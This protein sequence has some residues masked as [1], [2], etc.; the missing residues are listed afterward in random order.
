MSKSLLSDAIRIH[1]PCVDSPA[2]AP[3]PNEGDLSTAA[4]EA[5]Q[6]DEEQTRRVFDPFHPRAKYSLHP[7][8]YLYFCQ[9]C[10]AIR[11]PR[12]VQEEIVSAFCPM[13]FF[14]VPLT[15]IKADG[16]RHITP[17]NHAHESRCV[18]NCF[19]CPICFSGL[20]AFANDE[21][22]GA[23]Y[24]LNCTYC[25]WSSSE[26]DV[27]FEKATGIYGIFIL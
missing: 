20:H 21:S 25:Q 18:R 4:F 19:Q 8:G 15:S 14:E 3:P 7:I 16:N 11:C 22:Q 27:E 6:E 2:D 24:T 26:I 9:E 17:L 1:C 12:C 10:Q 23:P 13:C 5:D